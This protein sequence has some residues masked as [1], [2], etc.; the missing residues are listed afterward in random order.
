MCTSS[1]RYIL[2]ICLYEITQANLYLYI[3]VCV[4]I[5][6]YK[7]YSVHVNDLSVC[8]E[9]LVQFSFSACPQLWSGDFLSPGSSAESLCLSLQGEGFGL[10]SSYPH[11]Q[12]RSGSPRACCPPL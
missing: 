1:H 12:K 6:M 2:C 4:H 10:H 7:L 8:P 3:Y 5:Y 9:F 11:A